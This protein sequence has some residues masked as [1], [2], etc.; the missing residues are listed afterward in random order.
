MIPNGGYVLEGNNRCR[1]VRNCTC[2]VSA[3]VYHLC[4]LGVASFPGLLRFVLLFAFTIIPQKLKSSKKRG[5][6]GSLH[7]VNDVRWT[8]GRCTCE[9]RW[10]PT[11]YRFKHWPSKVLLSVWSLDFMVEL[12][13]WR[14]GYAKP[15]R[16][17]TP[18]PLP[19]HPPWWHSHYECSPCFPCFC[20][21][22]AFVYYCWRKPKNKKEK[23]SRSGNKAS[24]GG[25]RCKSVLRRRIPIGPLAWE[26]YTRKSP[27]TA[28]VVCQWCT[29][30]GHGLFLWT[31][32]KI[33]IHAHSHTPAVS[34][35]T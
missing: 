6:S 29:P 8:W 20:H 24:G 12:A 10:D 1:S 31:E 14:S 19:V 32:C 26:V 2:I 33:H 22:P 17:P 13:K 34:M 7:H 21:S 28:E 23:I 5:R 27:N 35:V 11:T 4:S 3:R 16:A 9:E 15:A 25:W 30:T 18:P